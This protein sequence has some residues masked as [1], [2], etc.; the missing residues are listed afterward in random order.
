MPRF[1]RS[2]SAPSTPAWARQR[3]N[4]RNRVLPVS[5]LHWVPMPVLMAWS[6]PPRPSLCVRGAATATATGC[7]GTSKRLA[8]SAW[9]SKLLSSASS[10]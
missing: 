5:A 8:P 3:T 6:L 1:R 4:P 10:S 9:R 2:R 7:A